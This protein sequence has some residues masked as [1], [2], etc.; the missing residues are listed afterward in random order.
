MVVGSRY[1]S[2]V[3]VVNWPMSRVLLSYFA[4]KYVRFLLNKSVRFYSWF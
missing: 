2:G 3:N 1:I 4:S